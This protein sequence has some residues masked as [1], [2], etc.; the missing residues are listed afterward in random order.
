VARGA[1]HRA[2]SATQLEAAH[3]SDGAAAADEEDAA[4]EEEEQPAKFQVGPMERYG[5]FVEHINAGQARRVAM[6]IAASPCCC[7]RALLTCAAARPQARIVLLAP[8][9]SQAGL[10][11]Q[12]GRVVATGLGPGIRDDLLSTCIAAKVE[13]RAPHADCAVHARRAACSP[14]RAA[15]LVV[16]QHSA[17]S[18]TLILLCCALLRR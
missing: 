1:A 8:D 7:Q 13:A 6:R 10:L 17:S 4:E 3:A 18:P 11:L 12:D 2:Q 15:L 16:R 9:G 14:V 5:D